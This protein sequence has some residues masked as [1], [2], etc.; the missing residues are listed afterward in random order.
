MSRERTIVKANT[1]VILR[2]SSDLRNLIKEHAKM[3]PYG[4]FVSEP[5]RK[6]MAEERERQLRRNKF[7]HEEVWIA[8]GNYTNGRVK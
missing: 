6:E 8:T 7:D 1:V 5:S 3:K 4:S 2:E